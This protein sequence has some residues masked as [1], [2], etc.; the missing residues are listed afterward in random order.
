MGRLSGAATPD[1]SDEE[2]GDA[3]T[4]GDFEDSDEDTVVEK[5]DKTNNN[6]PLNETVNEEVQKK[7]TNGNSSNPSESSS[8]ESKINGRKNS[9]TH[10]SD[11]ESHSGLVDG[12]RDSHGEQNPSIV[13]IL[14]NQQNHVGIFNVIY[15]YLPIPFRV[16]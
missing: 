6:I 11:A 16:S 12:R 14:G 9:E 4:D 5:N 10:S 8:K 15:R 13:G 3:F 2:S 1:N 7:L